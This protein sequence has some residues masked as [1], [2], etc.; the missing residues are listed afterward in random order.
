MK[1]DIADYAKDGRLTEPSDGKRPIGLV[2]LKSPEASLIIKIRMDRKI[3]NCEIW[4]V[5][6][7]EI[8]CCGRGYRENLYVWV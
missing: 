8:C 7:E 6:F 2:Y 4:E 3:K 1:K 5:R